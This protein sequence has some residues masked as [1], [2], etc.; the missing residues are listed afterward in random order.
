MN[1]CPRPRTRPAT[2]LVPAS[3]E[4]NTMNEA[5]RGRQRR[6]WCR[7]GVLAAAAGL[8]LLT[9][10]CGSTSSSHHPSAA[11][12]GHGSFLA[13]ELAFSRCVRAHG[14]PDFPDPSANG[15]ASASSKQVLASNPGSP[16]AVR[17]CVH[18]LPIGHGQTGGLTAQQQQD[19]LRAVACMR[20]H[21][22]ASFPDPV[23]SGGS[24]SFPIPSSIDTSSERFTQ[25]RQ[26]CARLIPA[27]LPYSSESGGS[28]G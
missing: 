14:V 9:A 24:V 11:G 12:T 5:T 1:N 18:L 6:G 10:A 22:I 15:Q 4:D 13:D 7:A 3:H 16:A 19:Y 8:V 21:G 28:G 23:F 25:A 2:A 17:A 20:S 26:T 27:G